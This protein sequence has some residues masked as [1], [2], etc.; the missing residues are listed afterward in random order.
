MNQIG[1]YVFSILSVCIFSGYIKTG[2]KGAT[3]APIEYEEAFKLGHVVKFADSGAYMTRMRGNSME[4]VLTK[5]TTSLLRPI[6]FDGLEGG[7]TFGCSNGHGFC[8]SLKL[9]GTSG[10]AA[11]IAKG[12]NYAREGKDRVTQKNLGEVPRAV[13]HIE[14]S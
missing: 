12:I 11:W 10:G 4:P 14:A 7:M 1:A 13:L 5:K 3:F 2:F 9:M 6:D 8:F